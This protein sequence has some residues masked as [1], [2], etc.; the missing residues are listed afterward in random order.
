MRSF[1]FR[2]VYDELE[3]IVED[4]HKRWPDGR[5]AGFLYDSS[6]PGVKIHVKDRKS[7]EI[8]EILG[9][10]VSFDTTVLN[11]SGVWQDPLI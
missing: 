6:M 1:Q 3:A 4:L 5:K 9:P 8:K 2:I 7:Y 10:D 11:D